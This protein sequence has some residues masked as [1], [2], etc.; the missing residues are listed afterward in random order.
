MHKKLSL[1]MLLSFL[2]AIIFS[3][4]FPEIVINSKFLGDYF[5]RLLKAFVPFLIFGTITYSIA[6]FD[7]FSKIGKIVPL[8]LFFYIISTL[9]A[10]TFALLVGSYIDFGSTDFNLQ[11]NFVS[12][13]IDI[14]TSL[15]VLSVNP[16]DFVSLLLD[17][18]PFAIMIF[19][20]TIGMLCRINSEY[21]N[22]TVYLLSKLNILV[23]TF[24]NYIMLL[25]PL[26]IFS[27]LGNL[28]IQVENEMIYS[29]LRFVISSIIIFLLYLFLFY[30]SVVKYL[31][32]VS[33]LAFFQKIKDPL[34]FAFFS[35]SSAATM[36]L[37]LKVAENDLKLNKEISSFVIPIGVTVN[38]DGSAIYLGLA[39][40]FVGQI[41]G[42]NFTYNEYLII[43]LTAT[44]GSI[45][46][47]GVPSVALVMMTIVFSSV[48]IPLEAI[49]II[50]GVDRLLDMFRTSINVAGDL[51]ISTVVNKIINK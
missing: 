13:Q 8:T 5:I 12:K 44:I 49:A 29:L 26:A 24:T 4:Y 30:G 41:L 42:I 43:C 40:L 14:G 31:G 10:I 16:K 2:L 19:S 37:T 47:A 34:L 22:K 32:K 9:I 11:G 48:G 51:T 25:A 46:A 50:A 1:L 20:I 23:I 27:L 39:A 35:S 28:L 6:S 36:P 45:G 38:M 18:N 17:A 7:A 3:N 15:S 21:S 33:P